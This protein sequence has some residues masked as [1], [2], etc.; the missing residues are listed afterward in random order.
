MAVKTLLTAQQAGE[1]LAIPGTW[2]L[3]KAREG[4]AP[5]YKLGRYV[6]FD[7]DELTVWWRERA[8]G[9]WRRNGAAGAQAR[10]ETAA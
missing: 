5:H 8:R 3:M 10:Q 1:M 9:P 7:A 2:L 4:E 6:R